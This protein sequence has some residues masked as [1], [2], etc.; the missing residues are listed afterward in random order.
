[1]KKLLSK[2]GDFHITSCIVFTLFLSSLYTFSQGAN[3]L[4]VSKAYIEKCI[5]EIFQ[6]QADEL[7]FNSSSDR[8]RFL[9]DFMRN[10]VVVE[11]RPEYS[12]KDFESTTSLN[13]FTKY[14]ASLVTDEHYDQNTFNPLKYVYTINTNTPKRLMYRIGN[15]DHIMI[16][17]P[18]NNY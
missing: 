15:S 5:I 14:N 4:N 16:I 8:L 1:M 9:S 10:Q 13:V 17:N 3:N 7:V 2:F 11:Y 18:R 12:G 6:D